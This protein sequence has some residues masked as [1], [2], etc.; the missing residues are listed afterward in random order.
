MLSGCPFQRVKRTGEPPEGGRG[1]AP[2]EVDGWPDCGNRP[3]PAT[4]GRGKSTFI[5]TPQWGVGV[6]ESGVTFTEKVTKRLHR[7][8]GYGNMEAVGNV[9]AKM[10]LTFRT[11]RRA[12]ISVGVT[13]SGMTGRGSIR[14]N[15]RSFS[16]ANIDRS[17][18]GLNVTFARRI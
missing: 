2:L 10:S 13:I 18:T 14:H 8:A 5:L 3:P 16:A 15:N 6:K 12:V 7:P 1:S 4:P 17:R 11:R 9:A